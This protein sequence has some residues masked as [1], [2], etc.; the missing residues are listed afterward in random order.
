V[1]RNYTPLEIPSADVSSEFLTYSYGLYCT[2][3][4]N[5]S[6]A[7]GVKVTRGNPVLSRSPTNLCPTLIHLA[8]TNVPASPIPP[9][10]PYSFEL[11][12]QERLISP[13]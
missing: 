4:G 6:R 5:G 2:C 3:L 8:S 12:G 10:F 13:G 11:H 9:P 1:G 7:G